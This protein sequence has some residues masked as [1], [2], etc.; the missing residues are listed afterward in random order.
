MEANLERIQA[1]ITSATAL[2]TAQKSTIVDLKT[3]FAAVSSEYAA[4]IEAE[5]IED[6]ETDAFLAS[7]TEI[8]AALEATIAENS[9]PSEP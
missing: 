9:E 1:V 8:S 6:A 3:R 2:I 5:G 4:S 7:L